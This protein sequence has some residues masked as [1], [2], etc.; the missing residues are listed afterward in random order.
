MFASAGPQS[1]RRLARATWAFPMP[2]PSANERSRSLSLPVAIAGAALAVIALLL[3]VVAGQPIITDDFWLHLALGEAYLAQGPWLDGDPL[4]AKPLGPPTPAAWLFDVW[5][6]GAHRALGFWGLRALHA[7][8]VG[9]VLALVWRAA[10]RV[11]ASTTAAHLVTALFAT[12]SAY[13]LIQLRPH[14]FTMAATVWLVAMIASRDK[15]LARRD[16][17]VIALVFAIWANVHAAFLLG[18]ILL[19]AGSLGLLATLPLAEPAR[20]GEQRGRAASLAAAFALGSLATLLNPAGLQP[21]L[22]FFVA[23]SETPTLGRVADEWAPVDL[24]A[25]PPVDLPPSLLSWLV[26][27]VLVSSTACV[28]VWAIR[29]RLRARSAGEAAAPL[30]AVPADPAIVAMALLGCALPL[31]AVRFQWLGVLPL[32]LLCDVGRRGGFAATGL[33]T[34]AAATVLLVPAFMLV[35]PWPMVSFALPGSWAGYTA[36]YHAGKYHANLIWMIHDAGLEGTLFTDYHLAGFAGRHLAPEVRT[37]VNGTLNVEPEV[38]AANLPLRLRRG[39]REGERFVD[40]LDRHGVDLYVG[41]RLP[42]VSPSDRPWLHTTAH[43]E[44]TD[45]WVTVFR[46]MNGAVYLRANERNQAN[47]ARVVEFYAAQSIEFDPETGFDVERVIAENYGWARFHGVIPS[48]FTQLTRASFGADESKKVWSRH[49]LA[50][51]YAVLGMYDRAIALD[52]IIIVGDEDDTRARR[53][54]VWCLM[55]TGRFDDAARAAS[56]LHAAPPED[57]LSHHIATSAEEAAAMEELEARRSLV[58]TLPLLT[59]GE[60]AAVMLGVRGPSARPGL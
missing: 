59:R 15:G 26:L 31:V 42:R 57:V 58:A 52:E 46:N 3:V 11:S 6:A 1:D 24:F 20:R 36:S 16:F 45:G 34:Q 27:W 10:R 22:A 25:L 55:R 30:D 56:R 35:G 18:P 4:L 2:G 29:T 8:A 47:L 49:Q 21:H 23:G 19:A 51:V 9:G 32:L 38:I 39:E 43:L 7:A 17:I 37:L 12:L 48:N 54:L 13:R 41:I 44:R 60:A 40:L 33:W 14:L 50:T 28:V 53:R 5:L